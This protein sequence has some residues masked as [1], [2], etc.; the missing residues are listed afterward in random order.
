MCGIAGY[1]SRGGVSRGVVEGMASRLAHRGPDDAGIALFD[2]VALGH[3]RLSIID[4]SDRG[5]QPMVRDDAWIVYNGEIYNYVELRAE[6]SAKGHAFRTD[7]DTEVVL[8]AY[9][10]WGHAALSRFNG[11]FAFAIWDATR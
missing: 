3:R 7:S 1:L 4:L 8:A 11:M 5:H 6:L 2:G 10:E 9:R